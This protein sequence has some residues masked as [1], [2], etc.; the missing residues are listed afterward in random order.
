MSFET[1]DTSYWLT[2]DNEWVESRKSQWPAIEKM[3][4]LNRNKAEVNVIKQYF[5]RG[6]LPNW[7]EIQEGEIQEVGRFC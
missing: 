1:F 7:G 6:K 3:V 5:L 2:K 4:G